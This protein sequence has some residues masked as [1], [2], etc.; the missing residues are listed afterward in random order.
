MD[1]DT[2]T[3]TAIPPTTP[4]NTFPLMAGANGNGTNTA[5][6]TASAQAATAAI[7]KKRKK[8]GLKPIITMD[9]PAPV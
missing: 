2:I 1:A 9:S 6:A 8:E 3:D 5:T 4:S 7:N